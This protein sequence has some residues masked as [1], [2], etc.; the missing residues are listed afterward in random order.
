MPDAEAQCAPSICLR[1]SGR[2]LR[3][4]GTVRSFC[5]SFRRLMR[6]GGGSAATSICGERMR[7]LLLRRHEGMEFVWT[8]KDICA[9]R[10]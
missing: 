6:V 8:S 1:I 10:G 2:T 5:P 4:N 7:L 3:G 9:V